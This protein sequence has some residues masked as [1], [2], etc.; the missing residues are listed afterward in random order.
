MWPVDNGTPIFKGN[1][2]MG[3]NGWQRFIRAAA[4]SKV[5]RSAF[6]SHL[7]AKSIAHSAV[8]KFKTL[9]QLL[10]RER[11][12]QM[13]IFTHDNA[14]A[15]HISTHFL[16]PCITHHTDLKER[17][18]LLDD[19]DEG[20]LTTLVTSR[21]L[22]EGVDIQRAEV[23]VIMSGSGTVREHVQRLGRILRPA[24]GK[25]AI[26]YELVAE[27]TAEENTSRRRRDHDAYR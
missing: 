22:N 16:I 2:R 11:G 21:V 15:Y 8:G 5:G 4:K 12:R 20:L 24:E 25:H 18:R 17:R 23:A 3:G 14:S 13:I 6:K 7:R 10:A 9:E 19:F 27:D 1:I 26:L